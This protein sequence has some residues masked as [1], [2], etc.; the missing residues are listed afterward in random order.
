MFSSETNKL[1]DYGIEDFS[2]TKD[3]DE[4][5]F[6]IRNRMGEIIVDTKAE[7]LAIEETQYQGMIKVY[8]NLCEL[9]GAIKNYFYEKELAY[10][11][12]RAC[13]WKKTCGI[14][15]RKR[16][17]QK[18]NAQKFIKDKFNIEVSEDIADAICLGYHV[19]TIIYK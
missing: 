11:V 9:M 15:G 16:I 13:E 17:E 1:L 6:K 2:K 3:P 18:A 7:V 8:K 12:V 19:S 14:K 10:V 4:R 5:I